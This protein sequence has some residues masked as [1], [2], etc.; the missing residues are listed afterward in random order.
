MRITV[1]AVGRSR[2]PLADAAET[3]AQRAGH[4]WSLAVREISDGAGGRADPSAVRRAEAERL[5]KAVG[6]GQRVALTRSGRA[7]DSRAWAEWLGG[8]RD[9]G[10]S[11]ITFLV[12]GA[13]GL[14]ERLITE[15][16]DTVSLSAATLPHDL[17]RVVLLEQLYRAGTILRGEPYHKGYG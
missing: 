11:A 2:G 16:H 14:E 3:Y 8:L 12:G 5:R 13:F 6:P 9:R 15:A 17:A 7:L 10:T 1:L 4:Y